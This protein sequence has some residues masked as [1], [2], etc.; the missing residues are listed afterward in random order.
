MLFLNCVVSR[1]LAIVHIANPI[2]ISIQVLELLEIKY[3]FGSM[4]AE[5]LV[6]LLVLLGV[7]LLFDLLK[8]LFLVLAEA[9]QQ[10]YDLARV[11]EVIIQIVKLFVGLLV[12]VLFSRALRFIFFV[13]TFI[14]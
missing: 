8:S 11:L 5:L 10:L 7:E 13:S 3:G 6:L 4:V 12:F 9:L 14:L 2:A 1:S